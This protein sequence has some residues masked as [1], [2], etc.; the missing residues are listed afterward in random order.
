[1]AITLSG[2]ADSVTAS[3][4][5][6]TVTITPS[7]GELIVVCI[8]LRGGNALS[9]VTDDRSQTYTAV[10]TPVLNGARAVIYYLANCAAGSTTITV[11]A[12]STETICINASHWAGAAT[13]SVVNQFDSKNDNNAVTTHPHGNTGVNAANGDLIV[14]VAGQTATITDETVA[15]NYTALTMATGGNNR[16]WWQY[17]LAGS[18]LTGETAPYTASSHGSAC[19]IASFNQAAAGG[20]IN[21]E[22]VTENLTVAEEILKTR[23]LTRQQTDLVIVTEPGVNKT[24]VHNA[25][26]TDSIAV[27]EE[28][29]RRLLR[30]RQLEE[31]LTVVESVSAIRTGSGIVNA[32]VV[33]DTVT[34]TD[35]SARVVG[36]VRLVTENTVLNE[37]LLSSI[38]RNIVLGENVAVSENLI[39]TMDL[40]RVMDEP[41][42]VGDDLEYTIAYAVLYNVRVILGVGK[43]PLLGAYS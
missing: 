1:M 9:S 11:T 25:V 10:T 40:V 35:D 31:A 38:I 21:T 16:H 41:I 15:T 34:I 33:T 7:A 23:Y 42:V 12:A 37:Q 4:T 43:D 39:R 28:T 26:V 2:Q 13:S 3:T 5:T 22:V 32:V 8:V 17:R 18:T 30:V 24:I 36:R 14:T 19:M 29:L 6:G 27:I 20:V